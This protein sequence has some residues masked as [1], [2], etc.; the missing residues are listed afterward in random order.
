MSVPIH[1][2]ASYQLHPLEHS[3]S[4]FFGIWNALI[5][6]PPGNLFPNSLSNSVYLLLAL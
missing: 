1:Y 6:D 4:A 3:Q 5:A 2:F